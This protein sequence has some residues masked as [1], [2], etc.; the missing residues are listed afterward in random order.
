MGK[1]VWG[2]AHGTLWP[3]CE[4]KVWRQREDVEL[5]TVGREGWGRIS[6]ASVSDFRGFW[7]VEA[8]PRWLVP[9]QGDSGP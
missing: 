1:L 8:V 2:R 9:A 7:G 5:W 6:V 3:G 4:E